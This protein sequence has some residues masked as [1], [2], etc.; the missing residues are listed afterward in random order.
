MNDQTLY[1]NPSQKWDKPLVILL[2]GLH[3]NT[4]IMQF[5][6]HYLQKQGF[7]THCFRYFSVVQDLNC[8]AKRLNAWLQGHHDPKTPLYL[9]GHS[10]GGL[11]IRQ[12]LQTYPDWWVKSCVTLGTPHQGSVCARYV[13]QICPFL[14][15]KAY[16][17]G[18]DGRLDP[19]SN[20]VAFGVIAGNK[21]SGM[22]WPFLTYHFWQQNKQQKNQKQSQ[23]RPKTFKQWF[24][25]DLKNMHDGTVLL[26]ES[27]LDSAQDYLVLPVSHTGLL[28]D[29]Q[30][31]Y[32]TAFFLRHGRFNPYI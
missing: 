25:F 12:F 29:Q 20:Q 13:Y 9:V 21:P 31:A 23:K 14:I 7:V 17:N 10:L 18:L 11:V 5:L 1:Q 24:S 15:K 4:W 22:G 2:H 3:Q 8:H 32:Q 27:R 6:A 30:A 19:P 28:F 16:F 26:T